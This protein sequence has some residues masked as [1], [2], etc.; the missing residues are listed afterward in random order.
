MM[1]GTYMY[2][3]YLR[4][5]QYEL[6]ALREMLKEGTLPKC[7][8]PIIEPVKASSTL[9]ISL[10]IFNDESHD[11][12]VIQN[13][14]VVSY[15]PFIKNEEVESLKKRPFFIPAV[16]GE[17][18]RDI[19]I[20][21]KYANTKS[22]IILPSAAHPA[23]NG[24]SPLWNQAIKVIASDNRAMHRQVRSGDEVVLED[25]F[26]KKLRNADYA[27]KEDHFFSNTHIFYKQDGY[28]GFSNYSIIGSEFNSNGFTPKAVV[29]HIVYF[30]ANEEL[31]IRHFVSKTQDDSVD[32]A[33]KFAEALEALMEW[34]HSSGFD[35]DRNDSQAL[36]EFEQMY[37][38]K[39]YEGLGVVKK[40]SIKHHL[41]IMGRYLI[42][43]EK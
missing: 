10:R 35:H 28:A 30:R 6:I 29:I 14:K 34:Y 25:P 21:A 11:L 43:K 31:W 37:K 40:L 24:Q 8:V 27:D 2:Y 4:G 9:K 19:S 23:L 33:G 13:S 38:D 5:K 7:V 18:D 26:E 17:A 20:L 36:K 32:V 3:P 22:M 16:I 1:G 12:A 41:E 39:H 42:G 15:E